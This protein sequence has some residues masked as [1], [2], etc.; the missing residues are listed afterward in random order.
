MT[1]R[2]LEKLL[3]PAS[4]ALI[5]ASTR[6]SSIGNTV[7]RNLLRGGFKGQISLINPRHREIEGVRC[8][9]SVGTLDHPPDLAVIATPPATIPSIAE[10]LATRGTKAIT[11]ISA[12][13]TSADRRAILE[14]GRSACVRVLGPNC[15]GLLVPPIGLNA[16]FAQA[17]TKPGKLA[18]L[19][20]SGALVTAVID[21][22]NGR[23]IGFS[24]VISLGDMADVDFGDLIDYLAGDP[25]CSA[26][27]MYI[28]A[29]TDARKFV[30]AARRAARVKPVIAIKSGRHATAARA[31]ASHT[32]ALAGSDAAYSA[33]FRR[34]GVL[35]VTELHELFDAAEMIASVP[36]LQG[37]R[38]A[39]LTNG[40]GAGVLATDTL[41]DLRGVLAALTPETLAKLDAQL[42]R[43]WSHGNP[44]DIVGDADASRYMAALS[45]IANDP[46][47]DAVLVMN[48]PT[49]LSS[50]ADIARAVAAADVSR[51]TGKVLL[52]NWLG[53]E[54]AAEARRV[55]RVASIPTF[56]T[57]AAAVS[58]FMQL[59]RHRRAQEALM[60]TPPPADDALP[61][62]R[63]AADA[64]IAKA[65]AVGRTLLSEPEGKA[66]LA[67][68]GIPVV[69]THIADTPEE[70]AEVARGLL[71]P[72]DAVVLKILS[73]DISHKSDVGG[74]K[75]GLGSKDAV[76]DAARTMLERVKAQKPDA[77][78]RGFTVSPFVVRPHAHELIL[79]ITEDRTFG[80]LVLFGAGGTSVEV[81]ADTALALPPIDL[82]LADDL[83]RETRVYRL[84]A[85]YRD[86]SAANMP[87]IA[88]ALVRLSAL[89]ANHPE[90]RELDINPLL[91]DARG[92]IALDARVRLAAPGEA[93]R[94]P[95][96]I[97][98]YP[99]KW[100]SGA[101]IDGVGRVLLRP[102]RPEDEP[103]YA[104]FFDKVTMQDRRLRLFTPTKHLTHGFLARLTQIDY[105]REIAFVAIARA[106]GELLGVVRYTADPDLQH[107][108]FA[109]IV[110]SDLK[111]RGLGWR[112]MQ[113]LVDY[114][115]TE[116]LR[117]LTGMVLEENEG[118]LKMCEE[119]GFKRVTNLGDPGVVHVRLEL[120]QGDA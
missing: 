85:G 111:G 4:V 37:E 27:L 34:A 115:K 78:L 5:G 54:S 58:G 25:N 86:R 110:R 89:S 105:A 44:I 93:P 71:K 103:L 74:V 30:S 107:G 19:S 33:A 59:V 91:A 118:M 24:H 109:V 108:E 2:N 28:E 8:H 48:C 51:K 3:N 92:V 50:S 94:V 88:N 70:A 119:M 75:L 62:D 80:P 11:V 64:V 67:A 18:F 29:I 7:A 35:R 97:R 55:F 112:L 120:R 15:L 65:L 116:N 101:D 1:I 13:V 79:G 117:A 10:E 95:M 26:I 56:D 61:I 46:A 14:A 68:Y 23:G 43:T 77:R 20:Q 38:L 87:A 113:Q 102:I 9:A 104:A 42:P 66:I 32:G 106:S 98:P 72:G 90:I 57:P 73:D 31:A 100:Q 53:A 49:A 47:C 22:A 63:G 60:R 114:A 96:A 17:S 41:A 39:I 99:A 12:G 83:M 36:G 69:E 40:G 81:T 6:P 76:L 16:S 21:W 52:T 84:L 45:I 82:V